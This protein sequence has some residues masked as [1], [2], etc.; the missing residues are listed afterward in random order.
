MTEPVKGS[1]GMAATTEHRRLR[2]RVQILT[3]FAATGLLGPAI[4]ALLWP[5]S[6]GGV[7]GSRFV[8]EL[9]LLLWPAQILAAHDVEGL[10]NAA[11][12]FAIGVNVL[13]FLVIGSIAAAAVRNVTLY[14]A[15]AAAVLAVVAWWALLWTGYDISY[16]NWASLV[17]ACLTYGTILY[18]ARRTWRSAVQ[19]V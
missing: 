11:A 12:I 2:A 10:A 13:L 16:L 5:P 14:S 3:S 17:T 15:F 8:H 19:A 9:V 18:M 1:S 7:A 4:R 6:Q